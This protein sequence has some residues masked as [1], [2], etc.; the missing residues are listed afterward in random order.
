M[1]EIGKKTH[2]IRYK[3]TP[4]LQESCMGIVE[5][6]DPVV[7]SSLILVLIRRFYKTLNRHYFPRTVL[8]TAIPLIP[9]TRVLAPKTSSNPRHATSKETSK[10]QTNT[11]QIGDLVQVRSWE[12]IKKTLDKNGKMRGL[13][14]M[15]SMKKYYGKQY[16]VIKIIQNIKLDNGMRRRMRAPT[17]FLEG[18]CCNG[19]GTNCDRT[20]FHF[21]REEWLQRIVLPT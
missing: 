13:Y 11:L 9:I 6:T 18:V 19:I 10:V 7:S 21:W 15:P 17:V 12:E 20:C 1:A 3:K 5:F 14:F 8:K 16:K 2:A 4:S